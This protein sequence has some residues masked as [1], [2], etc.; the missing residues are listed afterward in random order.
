MTK[1]VTMLLNISLGFA[2]AYF[3]L[4]FAGYFAQPQMW[5]LFGA[6]L[7]MLNEFEPS[8]SCIIV[9]FSLIIAAGTIFFN[10]LLRK[11]SSLCIGAEVFSVIAFAADRLVKWFVPPAKTILLGDTVGVDGVVVGGYHAQTVAFLDMAFI[12]FFVVSL[13]LMVCACCIMQCE[14]KT[15]TVKAEAAVKTVIQ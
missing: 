3:V 14:H 5:W 8:F 1:R 15:E 13:G 4:F 11:N 2:V 12:T 7:S 6:D 9:G 10:L